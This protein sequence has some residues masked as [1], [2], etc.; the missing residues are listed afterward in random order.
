VPGWVESR[1]DSR[2]VTLGRDWPDIRQRVREFLA[3]SP[4][5]PA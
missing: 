1:A 2:F 4:E 5:E 3:T